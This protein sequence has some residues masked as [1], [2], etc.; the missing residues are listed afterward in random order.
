[1]V[2]LDVG[3]TGMKGALL[4]RE[5]RVLAELRRPTPRGDGVEAVLDAVVEALADL[6]GQAAAQG[7]EVCRVGVAVPGIID[8]RSRTGV[9]SAAFG[10]H[11][12]P[13]GELLERRGSRG[14]GV[15]LA[16]DVR[17]A[18]HAESVLGAARGVGDSL[19]L[20]LG[21]GIGAALTCQGRQLSSG[22]YA[23]QLGHAVV[24]LAGADCGCGNRGCLST[25]ASAG[26]VAARY[27]A[28]TGRAVSGAAEVVAAVRA[29][30]GAAL[31]VWGAATAA[32]GDALAMAVCLTAP[33]L[34]VLGGGLA[35]AGE[36]LLEPVRA[37]LAERLTFQRVP[38]LVRSEL[39]DLAGC[40]GA[41]LQ[42]WEDVRLTNVCPDQE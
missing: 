15:T 35:L 1:M 25:V 27:T 34:V 36:L 26:A 6:A 20:T 38:V 18:G 9:Y 33:E 42:A 41:G 16:H 2:A 4:D 30:E 17:A 40:L 13:L 32:L 24:D 7:R 31:A 14:T 3:G 39:G 29:G 12:L 10:W 37:R 28:A 22:G 23:G 5:L 19:L 11:D 8:E 21:T